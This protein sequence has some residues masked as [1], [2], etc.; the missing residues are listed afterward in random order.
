[1]ITVPAHIVPATT[2]PTPVTLYSPSIINSTGS[3]AVLNSPE[4][5]TLDFNLGRK[6]FKTVSPSPVTFD[7]L[8][9]G[10]TSPENNPSLSF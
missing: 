2:S 4:L 9:I 5:G 1:M 10:T 6:D 3:A 7:T 8:K